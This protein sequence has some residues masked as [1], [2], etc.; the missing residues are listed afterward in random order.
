MISKII[1][2]F[3]K[4]NFVRS[5]RLNLYAYNFVSFKYYKHVYFYY[6]YLKANLDMSIESYF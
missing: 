1:S 4:Y 5:L 2:F 6:K 3:T